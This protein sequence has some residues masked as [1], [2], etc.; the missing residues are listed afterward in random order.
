M[1]LADLSLRSSRDLMSGQ[2]YLL[3]H[4]KRLKHIKE[5]SSSSPVL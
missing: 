4:Q 5:K 1:P 2:C 3:V